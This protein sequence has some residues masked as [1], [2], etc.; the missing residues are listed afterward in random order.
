MDGPD[1]S[2]H[3]LRYNSHMFQSQ[4][5]PC[6]GQSIITSD[7][8][9]PYYEPKAM[10]VTYVRSHERSHTQASFYDPC[11][12]PAYAHLNM[13]ST[14]HAPTWQASVGDCSLCGSAT[15][16]A[17]ESHN[18]EEHNEQVFSAPVR[19][20]PSSCS[21]VCMTTTGT[22]SPRLASDKLRPQKAHQ[23]AACQPVLRIKSDPC[24][25]GA[26]Q[27]AS[28]RHSSEDDSSSNP[29]GSFTN[30]SF[31]EYADRTTLSDMTKLSNIDCLNSPCPLRSANLDLAKMISRN[32]RQLTLLNPAH[33][34]QA[35]KSP[36]RL[37]TVSWS[38]A[39]KPDLHLVPP[40]SLFEST[41]S[42]GLPVVEE[43]G[44]PPS[45]EHVLSGAQ[46]SWTTLNSANTA[47]A[48]PLGH[49]ESSIYSSTFPFGFEQSTLTETGYSDGYLQKRV[50]EFPTCYPTC[51][52]F[53]SM[54][55]SLWSQAGHIV[56]RNSKRAF[57]ARQQACRPDPIHA[58]NADTTLAK[59]T[60]SDQ[61]GVPSFT[62]TTL[63][64]PENRVNGFEEEEFDVTPCANNTD[65][66]G[67]PR[68]ERTAFTKQQICELERE[69]TVHSYLTRLRRY[70]ISVALNLTERQKCVSRS[71]TPPIS[72]SSPRDWMRTFYK[73]THMGGS[74]CASC[75]N[76]VPDGWT[77][78]CIH[79]YHAS[80]GYGCPVY[81][82]PV[83]RLVF[84]GSR[85][86]TT[87]RRMKFI[88]GAVK[89]SE[90]RGTARKL[91]VIYSHGIAVKEMSSFAFAPNDDQIENMGCGK[92]PCMLVTL[93]SRKS[94]HDVATSLEQI[95][96]RR[97]RGSQIDLLV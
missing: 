51:P 53:H 3:P 43:L 97:N 90:T 68:K 59:L 38:K 48:N 37:A 83:R 61:P 17:V 9:P 22:A 11:N 49:T 71:P 39:Y 77:N 18:T 63:P 24:D 60:G 1:L 54:T 13:H 5:Y 19:I 88:V 85:F 65:V 10:T 34:G 33:P 70:E 4:T 23:P 21:G 35:D 84:T 79:I 28:S 44:S 52:D 8:I 29:A 94:T 16:V 74:A 87:L 42:L 78:W 27:D 56:S 64:K 7:F 89:R 93:Y 32:V 73:P 26:F 76:L 66:P 96:R 25:E 72:L 46:Y 31:N 80:G 47:M 67:R 69:F 82:Q 95:I 12:N 50:P 81:R 75:V 36:R 15:V 41:H 62:Q 20:D 30:H 2:R 55:E 91:R 86:S 57:F 45:R 40:F 14:L 58:T 6:D 92:P